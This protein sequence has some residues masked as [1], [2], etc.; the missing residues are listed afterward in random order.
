MNP[1][2]WLRYFILIAAIAISI[3]VLGGCGDHEDP[4]EWEQPQAVAVDS[5]P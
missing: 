5:Q 4:V 2:A 1:E 3:L